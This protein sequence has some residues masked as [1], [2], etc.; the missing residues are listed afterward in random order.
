MKRRQTKRRKKE[1]RIKETNTK[2]IFY[3]TFSPEKNTTYTR[4]SG[5][6]SSDSDLILRFVKA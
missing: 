6:L 1:E 3:L 2:T 5:L 4:C